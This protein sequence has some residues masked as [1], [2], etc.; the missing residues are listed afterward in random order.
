MGGSWLPLIPPSPTS[1]G[2]PGRAFV[3][4]VDNNPYTECSDLEVMFSCIIYKAGMWILTPSLCCYVHFNSKLVAFIFFFLCNL[5][6]KSRH[7]ACIFIVNALERRNKDG[8]RVIIVCNTPGLSQPSLIIR[9]Q[10]S[11]C[12][13]LRFIIDALGIHPIQKGFSFQRDNLRGSGRA[14]DS[15]CKGWGSQRLSQCSICP[16]PSIGPLWCQSCRPPPNYLSNRE[17]EQDFVFAPLLFIKLYVTAVKKMLV[18]HLVTLQ[19]SCIRILIRPLHGISL[20]SLAKSWG[21]QEKYQ[22]EEARWRWVGSSPPPPNLLRLLQPSVPLLSTIVPLICF[23]SKR[24][25]HS[26]ASRVCKWSQFVLTKQMGWLLLFY[27]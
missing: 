11:S 15:D 2:P 4:G 23:L 14:H 5:K 1:H 18:L 26:T 8:W 24:H 16:R 19:L 17:I 13:L 27:P 10:P 22:C 6:T 3:I 20:S 7:N 12:G 21:R 25:H 9:T